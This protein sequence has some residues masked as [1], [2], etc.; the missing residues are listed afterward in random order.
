MRLIDFPL[1]HDAGSLSP[2]EVERID[3][4]ELRFGLRLPDELRDFYLEVSG[5]EIIH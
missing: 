2:V 4:F 3:Q 1:T 5:T